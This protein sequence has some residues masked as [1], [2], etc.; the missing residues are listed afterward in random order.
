MES[1]DLTVWQG[2]NGRSGESGR[3]MS[4]EV[5]EEGD[6]KGRMEVRGWR[7]MVTVR[8]SDTDQPEG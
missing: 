5:E 4:E 7:W 1:S 3:Q 8:Q 6:G 2:M